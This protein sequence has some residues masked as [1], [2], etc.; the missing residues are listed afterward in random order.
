M[1]GVVIREATPA[2]APAVREFLAARGS[3]EVA[4]LGELV[5]ARRL[6]ALVA[7]EGSRLVGVLTWIVGGDVLEILTLH[8]ETQW[9]G[10]GTELLAGA[11]RTART[12][13]CHRI[14]LVTTN[15]NTDALRFYQR[16][17]FRLVSLHPGA[18]D[19][20]RSTLKPSIPLAGDHGIPLRDELE[21]ELDGDLHADPDGDGS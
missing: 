7:I 14:Q 6:P 13:G 16:R 11:Q 12:L 10:T 9:Q 17:G 4:R 19:R 3:A 8:V 5:D 1:T 18:V 21:L 2:D 15:D 20:S